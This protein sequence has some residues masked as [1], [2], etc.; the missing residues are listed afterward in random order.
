MM[1]GIWTQFLLIVSSLLLAAPSRH[2]HSLH[3]AD[4]VGVNGRLAAIPNPVTSTLRL[5]MRGVHR[6]VRRK[7]CTSIAR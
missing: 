6:L 4:A 1:C 7:V 2:A 3:L 5:L